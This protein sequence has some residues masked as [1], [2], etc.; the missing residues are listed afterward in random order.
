M[1]KEQFLMHFKEVKPSGKNAYTCLCPAH[2]DH[3]PSGYIFINGDYIH[4][5]CHVGCKR[6]DI[7]SC[8]GLTEKDLYIGEPRNLSSNSTPPIAYEYRNEDGELLYTKYVKY[9]DEIPSDGKKR[10]KIMWI[11]RPNGEKGRGDIPNTLFQ[12]PLLKEAKTIY[13]VEGEKCATAVTKRGY[14]ATTLDCGAKS[15][16]NDRYFQ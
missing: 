11:E 2:D 14:V 12:L 15:K 8:A 10:E 3:N 6:E 13:M 7:L 16:W 4:V 5:G 9:K 1:T